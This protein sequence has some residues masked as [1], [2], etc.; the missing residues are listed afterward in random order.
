MA[1]ASAILITELTFSGLENT[2]ELKDTVQ[3]LM[4]DSVNVVVNNIKGIPERFRAKLAAHLLSEENVNTFIS[5][6]YL[7]E[8][9]CENFLH[10]FCNCNYLGSLS[11]SFASYC[12]LLPMFFTHMDSFIVTL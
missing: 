4:P 10:V 3:N 11:T 6:Y 8:V 2:V 12:L 7:H 5:Y 9:N 1:S